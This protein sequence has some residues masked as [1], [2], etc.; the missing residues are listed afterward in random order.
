MDLPIEALHP[1]QISRAMFA[2]IL[3]DDKKERPVE[4]LR[5]SIG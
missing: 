1:H 2:A 4:A 3:E 5:T